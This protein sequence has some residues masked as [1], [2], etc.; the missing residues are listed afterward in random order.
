MANVLNNTER[1]AQI[2]DLLP[3]GA[4]GEIARRLGVS[5][6]AVAQVLCGLNST[7]RIQQAIFQY[8]LEWQ[9]AQQNLVDLGEVDKALAARQA[10]LATK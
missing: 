3:R 9:A 5:R 7:Q 8:F 2:R 1:L 10:Q 6:S 4:Q